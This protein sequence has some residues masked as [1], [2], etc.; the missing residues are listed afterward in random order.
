MKA[1]PEVQEPSDSAYAQGMPSRD[2]CHNLMMLGR[3]EHSEYVSERL[4]NQAFMRIRSA[5]KRGLH[6][7]DL[8]IHPDNS[9]VKQLR[10]EFD[11][12]TVHLAINGNVVDEWTQVSW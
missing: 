2:E 8:K 11:I 12:S 9:I 1:K 4:A 5:A 6:Q 7:V 10:E 3:K